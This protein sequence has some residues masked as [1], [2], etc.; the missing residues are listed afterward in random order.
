MTKSPTRLAIEAARADY[1][2]SQTATE[3]SAAVHDLT[4]KLGQLLQEN[5]AT[6]ESLRSEL[7][8]VWAATNGL[9]A[10]LDKANDGFD[11]P[12]WAGHENGSGEE[13]DQAIDIAIKNAR[14]DLSNT[15]DA[16]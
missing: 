4:G 2:Q 11:A 8:A 9:L 1:A 12:S 15:K 3:R 13:Y 10:A 14:A 6:V 5:D 16:I 7:E